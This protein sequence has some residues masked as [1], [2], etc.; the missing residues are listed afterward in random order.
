MPSK[1]DC[2]DNQR[3]MSLLSYINAYSLKSKQSTLTESMK[4]KAIDLCDEL[5]YC[6]GYWK[7]HA[8]YLRACFL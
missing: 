5:G 3:A 7:E 2:M 6:G 4:S 8:V 1:Y